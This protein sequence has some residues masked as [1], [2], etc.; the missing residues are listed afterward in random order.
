MAIKNNQMVLSAGEHILVTLL[1]TI[2]FAVDHLPPATTQVLYRLFPTCMV[3][4]P[5]ALFPI[6]G[7]RLLLQLRISGCLL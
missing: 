3:R 4:I 2:A 5:S 1:Q 7:S 6:S